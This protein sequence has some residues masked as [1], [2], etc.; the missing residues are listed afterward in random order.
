MIEQ[1][2]VT[3]LARHTILVRDTQAKE[4]IAFNS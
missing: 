1:H 2:S 4:A 3:D